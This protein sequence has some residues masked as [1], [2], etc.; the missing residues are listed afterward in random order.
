MLSGVCLCVKVDEE[1]K[2]EELIFFVC[3][4]LLKGVLNKLKWKEILKNTIAIKN[5]ASKLFF[6]LHLIL[7]KNER[8]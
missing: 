4:I 6:F 5:K 1:K 7:K 2:K 3:N 8:I